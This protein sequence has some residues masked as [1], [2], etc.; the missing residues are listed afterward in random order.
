VRLRPVSE[1]LWR[2][3]DA[4]QVELAGEINTRNLA[5]SHG[6]TST[7]ALLRQA[8]HSA[9]PTGGLGVVGVNGVPS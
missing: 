9:S 5:G 2:L 1:N 8:R 6:C 4:A 3:V 7:A